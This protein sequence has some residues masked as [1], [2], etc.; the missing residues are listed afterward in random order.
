VD[1][2]RSLAKSRPEFGA[3]RVYPPEYSAPLNECPDGKIVHDD[4]MRQELWGS[5]WNRREEGLLYYM[6]EI[7][8][9]M[10]SLA[11][12]VMGILTENFL[13][14]RTLG[15]TPMLEKENRERFSERIG[16]VAEK[17][18]NCD[19]QLPH[20]GGGASLSGYMVSDT[21]SKDNEESA[22]AKVTHGSSEL[23]IEHCQGQLTQITK[24]IA[25]GVK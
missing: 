25:F 5:C 22:L 12:D 3:F 6:I 18:S 23:A 7:E 2:L 14:M 8:Y 4:T 11:S 24:S 15:S 10:S 21:F 13:W 17:V 16:N 9:F 1:P 19:I 20:T